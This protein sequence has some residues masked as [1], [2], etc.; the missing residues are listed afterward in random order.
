MPVRRWTESDFEEEPRSTRDRR[1]RDRYDDD[2]LEPARKA[3]LVYRLIFWI[4]LILIFFAVGWGAMNLVFKWMDSRGTKSPANIADTPQ[5]AER[6]VAAAKSADTAA[7]AKRGTVCTL[8]IPSGNSFVS[9]QIQ[10]E[11]IVKEDL[12]R[13][14][15]AAYL[16]AL[17]ESSMMDPSATNLNL[18]Q[19]GE[20]LY[21]NM[22][23]RF[24]SSLNSAGADRS[25]YIITGMLRTMS[26][27][28]APIKKIK[29][30]IDG[31]VA[32]D[33]KPV[34]LSVEWSI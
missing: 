3:P 23:G 32:K 8:S 11:G 28:F 2:E 30:F 19:S 9:R 16:D 33:K 34:D 17:K 13:Q 5:E 6:I 27:N 24:L 31:K 7:S 29:F 10:C 25:R 20:W 4:A 15:V 21:L 26:M 18:F 22:N 12:M 14:T 1:D